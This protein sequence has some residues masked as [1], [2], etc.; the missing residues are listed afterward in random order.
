M[1]LKELEKEKL[2]A[3]RELENRRLQDTKELQE[4][5]K[6]LKHEAMQ[7]LIDAEKKLSIKLRKE[8]KLSEEQK[9]AETL[10]VIERL[11]VE[12]DE[13]KKKSN[14]RKMK[15][16]VAQ[17]CYKT[18]LSDHI[19]KYEKTMGRLEAKLEKEKV[20]KK[21]KK[22][23]LTV[24]SLKLVFGDNISKRSLSNQFEDHFV[25]KQF[26]KHPSKQNTDL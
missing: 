20:K 25:V 23:S 5:M 24:K 13:L 2:V 11:Q 26:D 1:G 18:Y 6:L 12:N 15:L 10:E 8:L 19:H 16:K 3:I 22:R 14:E 7:K 9:N 4:K 17:Q 21:N